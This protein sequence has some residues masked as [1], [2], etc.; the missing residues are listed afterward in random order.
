MK[1]LENP[2][3]S[4]HN[5][6]CYKNLENLNLLHKQK[7]FDTLLAQILLTKSSREKIDSKY[8]SQK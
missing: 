1:T 8:V 2:N 5:K 3:M 6:F 4:E 7:V